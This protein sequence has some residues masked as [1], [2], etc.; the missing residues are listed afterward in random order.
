MKKIFLLL[1]VLLYT[2]TGYSQ[3]SRPKLVVGIVVDQM[4]P[5]YIT[6]FWNKFGNG[7]FK[8]L[9][10]TGFNC[11]NTH[12]NYIP[13][14]TGPGHASIYTGTTPALH[15]ITGNN[16]FDS[17][18]NKTVYCTQDTTV[19]CAGCTSFEGKMSPARLLTST[20]TDELR[21]NTNNKAKVIGVSLKDRGAILPAGHAAN[22]AYWF[23]GSTGNFISSTWYINT[24]PQWTIDFN[25]RKWPD[26]YLNQTWTT[27]L[28]IESYSE[29]DPDNTPYEAPFATEAAPV[30]PHNISII[31]GGYDRLR[32]IP[33]G[34]TYTKDF[35]IASIKGEELGSDTVTD[36]LCISFSST[37][38]I[39]HQF[40]TYAIETEDAYL[41]LDRDLADLFNFLDKNIGKDNYLLFLTADHA[42][43]DNP[44]LLIDHKLNA[45]FF[46]D[47]IITDSVKTFLNRTYGK[48]EYFRLLI[49]DQIHLNYKLISSDKRERYEVAE[50]ITRYL[51]ET[52]ID[53]QDVVN[54]SRFEQQEFSEPF[55]N[56]MQKGY[57]FGRSG[58]VW[59]LYPPGFIDRL[60]GSSGR[61]GTTHGSPYAY[62]TH[63]PLFWMGKNIEKGMISRE[64]K[65]TDIAP[66]L[67]QLLKIPY[68]NGCTGSPIIELI[69]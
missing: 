62:D 68:P 41:R 15:G 63:V 55:R 16:W 18:E 5:D 29:S 52:F 21:I 36:F 39:G 13:T 10:T 6:R 45:G 60:Y 46:N 22:A 7:G 12:Y 44:V 40:G 61:Q 48:S 9:A 57:R 42:A 24:P 37:D 26:Q 67:A 69:R 30:F 32:R 66:T 38:Y 59:I 49:N 28:P 56:K 25:E 23:D 2:V 19:T 43:I 1:L 54:T 51:R 4:R 27:L 31:P 65:I 3:S 64:I 47:S 20:I 11:S 58:D 14:Y 35:A 53:F 34:N 50:A 8:R 17:K 33:S